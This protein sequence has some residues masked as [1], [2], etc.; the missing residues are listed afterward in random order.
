MNFIILN[1]NAREKIDS[2]NQSNKN[3]QISPVPLADGRWVINSD[4]LTD[5]TT[6]SKYIV[7]LEN[8]PKEELTE[9]DLIKL[10]D[11]NITEKLE[12]LNTL[13]LTEKTRLEQIKQSKT[14][15]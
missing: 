2:I 12:Q 13:Y 4:I 11:I 8:L 5:L 14:A 3:N 6:W 10:D 15:K 9:N 1:E 7:Y